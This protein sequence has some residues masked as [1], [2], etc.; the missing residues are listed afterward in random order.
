MHDGSY[1]C[2]ASM[3][4]KMFFDVREAVRMCPTLSGC[5]CHDVH[6][7]YESMDYTNRRTRLR[8]VDPTDTRLCS[9]TL[10]CACLGYCCTTLT[11]ATLPDLA[12]GINIVFYPHLLSIE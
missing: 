6:I 4:Y 10:Y 11:C 12:A 3:Q 1:V 9:D 8:N 2:L 7:I 5:S